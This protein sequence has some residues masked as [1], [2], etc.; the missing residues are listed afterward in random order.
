MTI[1]ST[2][3][4]RSPAASRIRLAEPGDLVSLRA[5]YN[6]AVVHTDATLDTD[7]KTAQD[8]EDW[9]AEHQERYCAGVHVTVDGQ[10][11]GYATLSAYARRGGYYPLTELS[12][13]LAPDAQGQG[14][15]TALTRWVLAQARERDFATV[16]G[17]VTTTN[18]ASERML[19]KCGF[20]QTGV[21]R[22]A[23]RKF[24]KYIDLGIWQAFLNR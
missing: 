21:M 4:F 15:G 11:C 6:H 16:V 20:E 9:L 5:V 10:V 23:G 17:F 22:Q 13:Y 19:V 18:E 24:G 8:F 7:E 1:T 2:A 12:V 3:V 14:Y